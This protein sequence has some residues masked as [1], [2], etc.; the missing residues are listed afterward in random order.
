MTSM[1]LQLA[2]KSCI[3]GCQAADSMSHYMDCDALWTVIG[4]MV[5]GFMAYFDH[6]KLLGLPPFSLP[7]VVGVWMAYKLYHACRLRDDNSYSACISICK[8]I[9]S[10]S[11]HIK[12]C[13]LCNYCA[14][15]APQ[16]PLTHH[17][18]SEFSLTDEG[19]HDLPHVHSE[20]F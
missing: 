6:E 1:R 10:T 8:A 13:K 5:P 12:A 18:V 4:R 7:Q 17:V 19:W 15:R 16:E 2:P 9:R 20:F 3:F 14:K 11:P